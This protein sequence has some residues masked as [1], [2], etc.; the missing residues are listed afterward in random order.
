LNSSPMAATTY[1]DT[2]VQSGNTYYYVTTSVN[3]AG[4]ES[5]DSNQATAVIP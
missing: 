5:A 2:T 3:S 1:T 4:E